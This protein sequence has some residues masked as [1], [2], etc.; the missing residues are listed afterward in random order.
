[1]FD[2]EDICS[3]LARYSPQVRD[4]P[5]TNERAAVGII[6]AGSKKNLSIC[7]IRRAKRKSDIWSGH[8]AL[9]GGRA[10]PREI[11]D[12]AVVERESQEEVGL[13]LIEAHR[14]GFLS[15]LEIRL[16]GR[17][18]RLTL[19]SLIYCIGDILPVLHP[20]KEVAKA[21]WVPSSKL[22]DVANTTFLTLND[23]RDL[24]VYPAIRVDAHIIWG[25]TL[26]VLTHFSDV[27]GHPLSH[28]EE[29]P[30]L[31]RT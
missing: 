4:I 16:A 10:Q 5:T 1:M 9:P 25:V 8:V 2:I 7:M 30:G 27:I 11:H 3:A 14:K 28:F 29:I 18:R 19:S 13:H 24:M 22:W 15:D 23:R 12:A 31:R 17:S 26:R 21:F 6:V 20:G